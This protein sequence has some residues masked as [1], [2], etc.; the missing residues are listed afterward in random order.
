[1]ASKRD[2]RNRWQEEPGLTIR[3]KIIDYS[4]LSRELGRQEKAEEIF[5]LLDGL[6]YREEVLNGRDLRG[7][8]LGGGTELDYSDT[9]FS[10]ATSAGVFLRCNLSR[11]RFDEANAERVSIGSNLDGASFRKTKLRKSFLAVATARGCCF[12]NAD[13]GGAS[14]ERSDLA[15]STFR[16]ANCTGVVFAGANLLGCDFR[17]ATLDLSMFQGAQIDRSTDLRG[18]SLISV[19]YEDHF[20]RFGN[21]VNKGV[22]LRLATWDAT[23]KFREDPARYELEELATLHRVLSGDPSPQKAKICETVREAIEQLRTQYREEWYEEL[24]GKLSEEDRG[25]VE[26][27]MWTLYKYM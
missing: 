4:T 13:L 17:G 5:A 19:F 26:E 22:D 12:D 8:D 16:N 21:L 15:G 9:D 3:Q 11:A 20:D 1:M 25:V 7:G 27:I 6:P 24:L 14:F 10:F 23:T 2:L 18:A